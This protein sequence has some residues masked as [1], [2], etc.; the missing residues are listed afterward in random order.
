MSR[1]KRSIFDD[2][3]DLASHLPWWLGLLLALV[4]YLSI[5]P[6]ASTLA[7]TPAIT[8][9]DQIGS[10]VAG[11]L[12]ATLATI[13]QYIVPAA[14]VLGATVSAIGRIKRK[15]LLE[16]TAKATT[17]EVAKSLSWREFEML[18][19]EMFRN[20]GFSIKET[21]PGPDGGV[22]LELRKDGEL[23]L[24]QCKQWRATKVGVG[25]VR[26]LFGVMTARGAVHAYVVTTGVFTSESRKFARG[27]NITLIDG[28]A[29][30][31]EIRRQAR[32]KSNVTSL[33]TRR[34]RTSGVKQKPV[35][36]ESLADDPKCPECGGRMVR[37]V[38]KRGTNA[39]KAFWG[40]SQFPKCR[41]TLPVE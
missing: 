21:A 25:V 5:H 18:V 27:R 32:S 2:L 16:E 41:G 26:E 9:A 11:Q 8:S 20:K 3:V 23:S 15:A 37:R 22:D 14:F 6:F 33:D 10:A 30:E 28:Q 35:S 36:R 7:T 34:Q 12:Y 13:G 38:A 17:S 31:R 29:V 39:G 24:V 4:S 40:C 1:K 19:G